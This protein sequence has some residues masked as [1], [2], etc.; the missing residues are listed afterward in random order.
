[1]STLRYCKIPS[2]RAGAEL[3]VLLCLPEGRPRAVLQMTHGMVEYIGRYEELARCLA[4]QGI[5][6]VGHDHLGHGGTA[7]SREEYGYV[8]RPDGNRLLLEDI[9]A[10]TRW[11]KA[12]P[13]LRG[14]PWF[15]LGHSMGSFYA[16]QYV[17][18]YGGE[19]AGAILMGTGWQPRAAVLAGRALC[20]MIA[21]AKGWRY[22]SKLVDG[23]A[24]GGYNRS[25]APARTP[26]DWLNRDEKEVDRY[27]AEERCSFRFTLN[28]YDSLFDGLAR[29]TDPKLLA[30]A[31]KDLPL[32][33]LAGED[34]PVGG[35]GRGVRKA[36]ESMRR[37][38]VRQVEVKLYPGAR[39]ELLVELNRQ[40]VFADIAAFIEAH[41]ASAS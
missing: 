30:R 5:A 26:K 17:C 31:P 33:F 16:R 13:E 19:L 14:L 40:E 38:G 9:H 21:L 3:N 15:L 25:F 8:G 18:E 35:R 2:T 29:L 7:A 28:G 37:A 24:F 36:A 23:M 22:R 6:A 34:D 11:A 27:L 39:H 10:V 20:H 1:M 32:L 12:L 4:Q 41:L